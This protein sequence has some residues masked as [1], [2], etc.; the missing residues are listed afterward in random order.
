MSDIKKYKDTNTI[1]SVS[2]QEFDDVDQGITTVISPSGAE[3][4]INQNDM[5]IA[6]QYAYDDVSFQIDPAVE[7]KLV[8]KIDWAILPLIVLLTSCQQMDKTTN[9]YASIMG[10]RSD[11]S[12]T[13]Q[14]YSWVGSIFYFGYM[15]FEYPA[16]VMLQKFPVM[17]TMSAAVIFWGIIL[18][19]HASC[20]NTPPFLVCRFLLG[21]GE[22]FINPACVLITSTWYKKEEQFTRSSIWFGLQG[23]GTLLGAGIA[24]GLYTYR[25]GEHDFASWRLLY[26]ITGIITVVLGAISMIHL[27]DI[28]IKAWFLDETEKRY[29][30]ERIRGNQQGFGNKHLKKE[31]LVEAAKD[32]VT[33][34]CFLYGITYSI[35]NASFTNFGSILLKGD[36]G[37]STGEALLMNMPGGSIDIVVPPLV[38]YLNHKFMQDKR[39]YS[40]A[41]VNGIVAVGMCLFNFAPPKGARL[42]GYLSFYAAT[43]V[44]AGM[45]SNVSSNVAGSTKKAAVSTIFLIGYCIGNIIGPQTFQGKEAPN[46]PTAKAIL[47]AAFIVGTLCIISIIIIYKMRNNSRDKAR[48]AMGDKYLVPENIEFADLTDKENPEFRYSL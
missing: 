44:M 18:M 30:V 19:C 36:F 20:Q 6:M 5:D 24:H 38:A 13:S 21:I 2:G 37:F 32:P 7:K 9:S 11:L 22:S 23:C 28:P 42:A 41:I 46:Y 29:C 31:Q 34:I 10:M 3:I 16:N 26:I 43:V 1:T 40:C 8:R 14:E 27:P 15:F 17:K 35:A 33:Y 12:M 47:L 45:L 48:E 25:T 4:H 39:L